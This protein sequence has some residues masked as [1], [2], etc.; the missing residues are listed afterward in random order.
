MIDPLD[1]DLDHPPY[2][3]LLSDPH[4][5]LINSWKETCK[6]AHSHCN[7]RPHVQQLPTR[8]LKSWL[9]SRDENL[10]VQL[11]E[12]GGKMEGKYACLSCCWGFPSQENQIGQTLCKNIEQYKEAIPLQELPNTIVDALRL[13]CKLGFEFLWVDRLCIVQD[14][15]TIT[16]T[17]D[18]KIEASKM[19]DYYSKSALTISVPICSESSQSFLAER[20]EG[21]REQRGSVM[22]EYQDEES[23]AKGS[24]WLTSYHHVKKSSWFLE[25]DWFDLAEMRSNMRNGWLGRGWTFQEWMLSPRVLH[26]NGLTLWDC[27]NGYANELDHREIR[28]ATLQRSPNQ[29]GKNLSWNSIV[30]EYSKRQVTKATDWLLALAG[31]AE[32][33]RAVTG[34]T[35]LA[36]IWEQEFPCSLLWQAEHHASADR[37]KLTSQTTPSWSW[38]HSSGPVFCSYNNYFFSAK[39][40]L[41]GYKCEYDPPDSISTVVEAWLDL[42]GPLSAVQRQQSKEVEAG[43]EWWKSVSDDGNEYSQEAIDQGAIKLFLLARSNER[44]GGDKAYGA[45]VLH[46][47][48]WKDDGRSVFRRVGVTS[49]GWFGNTYTGLMPPGEGPLWEQRSIRII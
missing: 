25:N 13:C 20:Q 45:L 21:L 17:D 44:Y 6:N 36:G 32:S 23:Q 2:R 19:C 10:N 30:K 47:C 37:R 9:D 40:S 48:G 4:I 38:A 29:F 28:E 11:V 35:Y 49:L 1:Q 42:D 8:V 16:G 14:R 46:E 43:D 24:L 27:F 39:A 18:W 7:Q 3:Y 31:L 41:S 5:D 34:W 33:Y 15:D 26:I 22:V 12:T